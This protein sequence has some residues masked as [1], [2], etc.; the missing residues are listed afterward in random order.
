MSCSK[1]QNDPY[2]VANT[3]RQ[4]RIKLI[5]AWAGEEDDGP[6][7]CEVDLWEMYR[8]Y[9]SGEKEITECNAAFRAEY[10]EETGEGKEF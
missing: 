1:T 5:R 9:I 4:Q 3:T 8:D 7:G 10:Y 6:G 2:S